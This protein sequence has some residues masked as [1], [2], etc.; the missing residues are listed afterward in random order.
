MK[1][2]H[3]KPISVVKGQAWNFLGTDEQCCYG[4]SSDNQGAGV[5]QG[6]YLDYVVKE[7]LPS[8]WLVIMYVHV[9]LLFFLLFIYDPACEKTACG[10]KLH[11]ITYLSTVTI[12]VTGSAKRGLVAFQ[13]HAFDHP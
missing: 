5:I 10:H 11:Y 13:L 12:F 3:H 2:G 7:L 8:L 1:I 4:H 9:E 6:S